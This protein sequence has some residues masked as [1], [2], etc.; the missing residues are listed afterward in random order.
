MIEIL[1][2]LSTIGLGLFAGALL[3]EGMIL[4][5]YWR[6]MDPKAFFRL[7]GEMGPNLFRY[8]AP[9]TVITVLLAMASSAMT[10]L[11]PAFSASRFIAGCCAA[12][13][14]LI[15]FIYFKAANQS[16]ADRSLPLD[17]LKSELSRWATWHWI[18]TAIIVFAFTLS[19]TAGG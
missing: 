10:L 17:A 6:K 16:F 13:T 7:H 1:N 4:V 19:V 3:T 18:R 14:L 5:P 11:S 8:F 2:S 9:L 15:F 12:L